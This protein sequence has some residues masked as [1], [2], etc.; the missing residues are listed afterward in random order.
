MWKTIWLFHVNW[1]GP[2]FFY[3]VKE[4]DKNFFVVVGS[5]RGAEFFL[6]SAWFPVISQSKKISAPSAQL[7]TDIHPYV[8]LYYAYNYYYAHMYTCIY[9]YYS[10]LCMY[11]IISLW[12]YY[13][14]GRL[15]SLSPRGGQNSL[16]QRQRRGQYF[17]YGRGGRGL[18]GQKNLQLRITDRR[19][20]SL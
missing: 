10:L 14:G 7:L 4:G 11:Y 6:L 16:W 2:K 19:P 13:S 1:R 8:F 18:S 9:Y 17:S 3:R 15:R 20:P 12:L 5:K